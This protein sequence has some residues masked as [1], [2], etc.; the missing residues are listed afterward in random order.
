MDFWT[1]L[2]SNY[3]ASVYN[4][5]EATYNTLKR[6]SYG[7]AGANNFLMN[8]SLYKA[9]VGGEGA[10]PVSTPSMAPAGTIN[11]T[12]PQG[13]QPS[14]ETVDEET[15]ADGGAT[16][17]GDGNQYAVTPQ[18]TTMK[19]PLGNDVTFISTDG[20][21]S[22]QE[23][24]PGGSQDNTFSNAADAI[25]YRDENNLGNN[26]IPVQASNGRWILQYRKDTSKQESDASAWQQA[27]LD[28]EKQKWAEQQKLEREKYLAT[29]KQTPR[30]W[31]RYSEEAYG[32]TPQAP[33]WLAKYNPQSQVGGQLAPSA[34]PAPSGQWLN[35]S[36]PTT[37][38]ML[39]GYADWSANKGVGMMGDDL[40][41]QTEQMLPTSSPYERNVWKP[42]KVAG[43]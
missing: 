9:W 15:T 30:D 37:R 23:Y 11:V 33:Q 18:F 35:R 34:L 4:N 43:W 31:I 17:A 10:P 40:L 22:W 8:T 20:G 41:S 13:V 32:M 5:I 42:T 39:L 2:K 29:L 21:I 1:W 16:G 25:K 27:Q 24:Q 6:G 7:D 12:T 28:W 19:D 3:P 14:T 38:D 36:K 26:Y